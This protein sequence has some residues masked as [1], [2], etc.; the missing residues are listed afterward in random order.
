MDFESDDED[1]PLAPA[2]DAEVDGVDSDDAVERTGQAQDP[3]A[4]ALPMAPPEDDPELAALG[5]DGRAF[6]I[7]KE[8]YAESYQVGTDVA[9][10]GVRSLH[11]YWN[12]VNA[13]T[14]RGRFVR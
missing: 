2:E 10:D 12:E 8:V 7:L 4:A 5:V 3:G 9:M 1:L 6:Q 13:E 11:P 14:K